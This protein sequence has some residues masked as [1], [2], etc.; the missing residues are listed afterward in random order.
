MNSFGPSTSAA[1]NHSNMQRQR[2][3]NSR[4]GTPPGWDWSPE[5][6]VMLRPAA[7]YEKL[8]RLPPTEAI[9]GAL[10]RLLF[11]AFLLGCM[12]SLIASQRLTLRHVAGGAI[13][14]SCILVGQIAALTVVCGRQRVLSF[15][16]A[17]DLFF[18][19][20]GPW[21]LW[22]LGFS[23][24]W[25][26][27]SP[28]QAFVWAGLRTILPTASLVALWS[29]YIDFCFFQHVLQRRPG[30]SAW[31]VLLLWAI[32]C[33]ISIAI[34]GGGPLWSECTRIFSR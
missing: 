8:A 17:I 25:A 19:G 1:A 13:S 4:R 33:S 20:Y 2:G 11:V 7:A 16:R 30:R 34:F 9:G 21:S 24:V 32:S 15:S 22:I 5:I 28:M 23:A 29:G 12:V 27:A 18:M 14:A 3:S 31:D 6:R 26:F 10:R